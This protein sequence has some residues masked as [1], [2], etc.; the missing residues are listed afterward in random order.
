LRLGHR[1][2]FANIDDFVVIKYRMRLESGY[3]IQRKD[4]REIRVGDFEIVQGLDKAILTM[5]LGER[6][7]IIIPPK[8][9]YGS[10]ELKDNRFPLRTIPPNA[11]L[12]FTVHLIDIIREDYACLETF[13]GRRRFALRKK[14]RAHYWAACKNFPA[15]IHLFQKAFYILDFNTSRYPGEA[16]TFT[17][18]QLQKLLEDKIDTLNSLAFAY[19]ENQQIDQAL[20]IIRTSLVYQ[21]RNIK[22]LRR[23]AKILET[24]GDLDGAID[25]LR[26][27]EFYGGRN[28]VVDVTLN[29]L[30]NQKERLMKVKKPELQE[31]IPKTVKETETTP[32]PKSAFS[33]RNSSFKSRLTLVIM[34]TIVLGAVSAALLRT[35]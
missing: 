24:I 26:T 33:R 7:E 18:G 27:A 6:S 2:E 4:R 23:K 1:K 28:H 12:I 34:G 11:K 17:N 3:T 19:L 25:A 29:R 35:A 16:S 8:Y 15:A 10:A 31:I 30:I 9:A 21:P 32:P 5:A 22:T 13:R 14:N 20:K